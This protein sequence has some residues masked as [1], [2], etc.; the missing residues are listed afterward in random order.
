VVK[1]TGLVT[2][3]SSFVKLETRSQPPGPQE[4][5]SAVGPGRSAPA[6]RRNSKPHASPD[7]EQRWL[8]IVIAGVAVLAGF[9]DR[10]LASLGAWL[11]ET[12]KEVW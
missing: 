1:N 2:R 5:P 11:L 10:Y 8:V 6:S 7:F 3:Y 4:R 9:F 12:A